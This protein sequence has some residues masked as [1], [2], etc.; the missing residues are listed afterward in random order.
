MSEE[1]YASKRERQKARRAE[2]LEREAAQ[3]QVATRKQRTV[4]AGLVL[5]VIA[6]IGG[7]VY[8]Q[9]AQRQA[10]EA[11]ANEVAERL[12]ELGCTTDEQRPDLG[13]G[14]IAGSAEALSAELPAIVYQ[15]DEPPSSG[16]HVGQVVAT[17]VYDVEIDPRLTTHNL[18]HGYVIVHYA[19][20]A[21][22][23]QVEQLKAWVA[24]A[25]DG[26]FP[27]M[28]LAPYYTDLANDANFS[29]TA[30]LY[31]QTCDTFDPDVLQVFADRHYET[32]DAPEA[33]VPTHRIGQQGVLDP[34]GEP[35]FFPPLDAQFGTAPALEEIEGEA[36]TPEVDA[37]SDPTGEDPT[38]GAATEPE[39][40]E[41]ES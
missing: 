35:L 32:S 34:E 21:P 36:A 7:L 19:P 39:Y 11:L 41:T 38:E 8:S 6:L 17:G 15:G 14:H 31:R 26:D 13:G 25:I 20:D 10:R 9:I 28:V 23:D 29:L 40:V 22:E 12:D 16:R 27:K 30:W 5:V 37:E 18:E 24:D 1:E 3:A 33:T 2:R 4:K